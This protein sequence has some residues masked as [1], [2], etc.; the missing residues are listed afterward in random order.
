MAVVQ[1]RA[2]ARLTLGHAPGLEVGAAL[3]GPAPAPSRSADRPATA[4]EGA[5]GPATAPTGRAGATSRG[6]GHLRPGQRLEGLRVLPI[7]TRGPRAPWTPHVCTWPPP[8]TSPPDAEAAPAPKKPR[9][10]PA[11]APADR[12]L[13][14]LDAHELLAVLTAVQKGDFTAR[15]VVADGGA[16]GRVA[17][18]LN[19]IIEQ[20]ESLVAELERRSAARVGKKGRLSERAAL[21]GT[22]GAW[23]SAVGHVNELIVDLGQPV[24]EMERVIGA[25]AQCDLSQRVELEIEGRPVRG[26][27]LRT[28]KMVN[29]MVDQLSSFASEGDPRRPRGR[30]RGR[31]GRPGQ[32]AR[33]LGHVERPDGQRELDGRQPD[34][35]GPQHRRGHDG[36]RKWRPVEKDHRRGPGR[37][38]RAQEHHQHDGRPAPELRVGV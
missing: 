18:T 25:V 36:R 28:A 33:R 9:P 19:A 14:D 20:N 2:H 7:R 11:P 16:V 4:L 26:E 22:T 10:A 1:E 31:A 32:G 12:G 34:G 15:L 24:A 3:D 6:P 23:R 21:P 37:D 30:D 38:P 29:T 35:P 5:R 27:F 13:C 8:N 17:D